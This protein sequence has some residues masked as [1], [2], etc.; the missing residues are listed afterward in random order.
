[1]S[2]IKPRYIFPGAETKISWAP[3]VQ[4]VSQSGHVGVK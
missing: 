3:V 4:R 2:A 1:M